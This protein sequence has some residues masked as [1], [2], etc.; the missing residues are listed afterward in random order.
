M[1]QRAQTQSPPLVLADMA[2]EPV[3]DHKKKRQ[4]HPTK[5]LHHRKT[6]Q[7]GPEPL[8]P[9]TPPLPKARVELR[10]ARS[11]PMTPIRGSSPLPD[12]D[13]PLRRRGRPP[14]VRPSEL[15]GLKRS[16]TPSL[17]PM[18]LLPSP[19][20]TTFQGSPTEPQRGVKP[21]SW[22]YSPMDIH[23]KFMLFQSSLFLV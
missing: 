22:Y 11:E 9:V 20:A 10:I 5:R 19:G 21:Y 18:P 23:A 13:A 2:P 15:Q 4:T 6:P 12:T 8:R 14:G 7:P 1:V 17:S 3:V 16:K